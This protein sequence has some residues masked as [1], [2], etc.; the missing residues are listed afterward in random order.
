[1]STKEIQ[2]QITE[3]MKKWQ[4]IENASVKSTGKVIEKT[5]N[6]IVRQIM[7]IIQR[8]SE[9]H[10]RIQQLIIDSLESMT[11]SL[12]P[13]ELGEV[14][15][16]IE[17]HIELEKQTIELALESLD[18]LKGRKMVIQEYLLDYLRIDEEK[19]NQVLDTLATIKKGMY[20]YG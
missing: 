1:M 19:H 20:P 16:L 6:P 3:N 10:H 8:D 15:D 11:I 12:T 4:A 18:A 9:T 17:K 7:E 14:W 5:E 2:S 13:E